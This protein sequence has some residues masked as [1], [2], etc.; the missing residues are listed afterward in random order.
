MIFSSSADKTTPPF[1]GFIDTLIVPLVGVILVLGS[2]LM[3]YYLQKEMYAEQV[4]AGAKDALALSDAVKQF[5]DFYATQIVPKAREGGLP[6]IHNYH[7]VPGA[8]P[9]PATFTLDFGLFMSANSQGTRVKV[10]SDY[11]F[12]W[13]AAQRNL[14]DFE[15][16]ALAALKQDPDTPYFRVSEVRGQSVLQLAVSDRLK[17]ACIHCHN[18]YPGSPKTD[19]KAGDVRGVLLI[20]KP[21]FSEP[22][23]LEQGI[24]RWVL[25]S[26]VLIGVS[27]FLVWVVMR[28]LR[29]SM[30]EN[31]L[32][33]EQAESARQQLEHEMR[34]RTEAESSMRLN[35]AK[36]RAIFDSILEGVVVIDEEGRIVEVNRITCKM[37]GYGFR[38][39]IGQNV[40]LLMP[41]PDASM[42]DNY[43]KHFLE[44]GEPKV[45]GKL[46]QVQ[47]LRSD[48][49]QF[50]LH[51]AVSRV[52]VEQAGYFA[53]VITDI[54][55][56]LAAEAALKA[57]RD[58]ALD[59]ARLKSEFL[60]NMSHEIR[61]PMNGVIGMT[62]LLSQ[63]ALSPE[64]KEWLQTIQKSSEALLTVINDIL[65]FS[66]IEAGKLELVKDLFDPVQTVEETLE[67]FSGAASEKGLGLGYMLLSPIP[68]QVEGDEARLRQILNNLVGNA[69]KFTATGHVVVRLEAGEKPGQIHFTVSDT[70]MGIPED[71]RRFL[72]KPFSQIDGSITR[73]FGGTGLGLVICRQLV[74]LMEGQIGVETELGQGSTFWFNVSF[75]CSGAV[76]R[77]LPL[78]ESAGYPILYWGPDPVFQAQLEGWGLVV[79]PI[80]TKAEAEDIL[81]KTKARSLIMEYTGEVQSLVDQI[82]WLGKTKGEALEHVGILAQ[83]HDA[84][85]LREA[86]I[87]ASPFLHRPLR[88]QALEA[89][90]QVPSPLQVQTPPVLIPPEVLVL[91]APEEKE[92]SPSRA[93]IAQARV[94][95][96]EDNPVNQKLILALLKRY[97]IAAALAANGEDGL[98]KL[99]KERWDLV[100]MD[101]Q[102]PVLDGFRAAQRWRESEKNQ[103]ER[104][105]TPIVALTANAM[106]GDRERCLASGMD[107]YLSKPIRPEHLENVLIQWVGLK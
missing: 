36:L 21:L 49:T 5:R 70:G 79:Y 103:P 10:F 98:V 83:R 65:D 42:H 40:R 95:V 27:L 13:R 33:T 101:C 94:L 59:S 14:D 47:G 1:S 12:P 74:E 60:A 37:F 69:V 77:R 17:E 54:T 25:A 11:P 63:T 41:E 31:A 18:T 73:Q 32:K 91:S 75:E 4:R 6:I 107:D 64:Q 66:K 29:R 81:E 62:Y 92:V 3:L 8:L 20:E 99:E 50:S 26:A 105:H 89:F 102:M 56:R 97:G 82:A 28:R 86:G 58:E 72:F 55:E 45:I 15:R 34:Q 23:M 100:F 7:E 71:K 22:K 87:M 57:A 85:R 16:A 76:S 48:G 39:L 68:L 80:R 46:R 9:L 53:A 96:V 90:L 24:F 51:L 104:G 67:L 93:A 52:K 35:E 106:E 19:W 78:F 84:L 38:A 30:D 43:I 61:T 88:V 44:G 2:A